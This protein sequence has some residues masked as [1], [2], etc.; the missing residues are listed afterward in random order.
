[1]PADIKRK[2]GLIMNKKLNLLVMLV[3][4]LVLS[5]VFGSCDNGT[6]SGNPAGGGS[7]KIISKQT[8]STKW[9][10]GNSNSR[11]ISFEFTTDSIY[12][13]IEDLSKN[14]FNQNIRSSLQ[15]STTLQ[16]TNLSPIHT[17]TYRINGNN[18]ILEGFGVLEVISVT[19]DEFSFSFVLENTN[20]KYEYRTARA[21]DQIANSSKTA[22]LCRHWR[23]TSLSYHREDL[24][25]PE[26]VV[27]SKAGTYLVMYNGSAGLSEWKWGDP[28]ETFIQYS[29]DNWTDNGM[30]DWQNTRVDILEL[31]GTNLKM[32]EGEKEYE[33]V[34]PSPDSGIFRI[35]ITDIPSDLMDDDVI[36]GLF[37]ANT[38][39]Y[40]Y[41]TALAGR[42][43]G[44]RPIDDDGGSDW[45]EFSMYNLTN[46]AKYVGPAGNYDIAF[47]NTSTYLGKV[48][49]NRRLEVSQKNTFSY[50]NFADLP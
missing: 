50:T 37:S 11:Y 21:E 24:P 32:Q 33:L 38:T 9:D 41:L 15:A 36:I 14:S 43:V 49:K 23:V 8:I 28:E 27:F 17:G 4:L 39:I 5:L 47:I 30:D 44:Y 6:N 7:D 3:S 45:Y 2:E 12:I 42:I 35:K 13:V 22:M 25:I 26:Q 46:E 16:E 48:L 20:E 19:V 34:I 29:W 10:V 1:M 31:S 40:D 18:I